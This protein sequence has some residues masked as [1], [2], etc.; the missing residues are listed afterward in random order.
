M[1]TVGGLKLPQIEVNCHIVIFCGRQAIAHHDDGV[2]VLDDNP[3]R[4]FSGTTG[5]LN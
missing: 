2:D 1:S 3:G 4:Q 5:I